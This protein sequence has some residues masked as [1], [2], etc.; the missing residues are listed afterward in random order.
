MLLD[1]AKSFYSCRAQALQMIGLVVTSQSLIP[2]SPTQNCALFTHGAEAEHTAGFCPLI[3][4]FA[5]STV[6]VGYICPDMG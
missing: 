4:V 6:D 2:L 3:N 5:E 1:V